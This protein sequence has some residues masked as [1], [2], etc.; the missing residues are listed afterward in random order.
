[1]KFDLILAS[2]D[3]DDDFPIN[4]ATDRACSLH[5]RGGRKVGDLNIPT[6]FDGIDYT[7]KPMQVDEME[8]RNTNVTL[9]NDWAEK[10]TLQIFNVENFRNNPD[11]MHFYTGLPDYETFQA[12]FNFAKPKDGYQLN[13]HN[14]KQTNAARGPSV[15]KKG[16]PRKLSPEN[17]LFLTLCRLR[18]NL[19]E[20][21]LHHRFQISTSS[22][23]EIF[24]TWIDRLHYCLQ[25]LDDIPGLTE[26]LQSL[27]PECF[28]GDFEDV[29]LVIDC[30]EV[31]IERPSDPVAQSATWSE[32]KSHNTGKVLIALSPVGYPRFVSDVS[33]GSISDDEKT[34]ERGILS[35]AR[36]NRRWL[37]DKGWQTDG[38]KFGLIIQTPDRLEGKSQF[39]ETEDMLNRKISRVRI[40]VERLIRRIKVFRMF[41][42]VVPISYVNSVSKIFKVCAKL[43]AFLPPIIEDTDISHVTEF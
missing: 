25:S 3:T 41:K 8:D 36:R 9:G 34:A 18:L 33:P 19:L 30:T 39:S 40:H 42:S 4:K 10:N 1:M 6:V 12:L 32:Y 28:K 23:S 29:D 22:V 5:F 16:R 38:D 15:N 31:F 14:N 21:D 26:G 13:Y 37:A 2:T 20:E 27:L 7:E 11:S 43:T 35:L 24:L 17:E